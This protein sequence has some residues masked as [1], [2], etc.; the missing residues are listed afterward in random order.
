M[1]T[2]ELL[3][4]LNDLYRQIEPEITRLVAL[5]ADRLKCS[6]GCTKCCVDDLTVF[7]IEAENI[8]RTFATILENE[9]PAPFGV[10][11]MLDNDGACRIYPSRPYVCRTQGLPLRWID[12]IQPNQFAEMRDICPLNAT[13][14][15]VET[16][17]ET[18]CWTIGPVESHL[19][20]LQTQFSQ[21]TLNRIKLRS[22]FSF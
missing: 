19:A 5:H 11:A 16:L 18:A 17:P 13:G 4:Q 9:N 6:R 2:G 1:N 14:K 15:P 22:L 20:I 12:E 7:E 10:C 8:R 21:G 3:K